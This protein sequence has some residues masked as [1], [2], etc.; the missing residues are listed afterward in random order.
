MMRNGIHKGRGSIGPRERPH[1]RRL[2]EPPIV[3][4]GLRHP[5]LSI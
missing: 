3:Q 1:N 5:R 2:S 4:S